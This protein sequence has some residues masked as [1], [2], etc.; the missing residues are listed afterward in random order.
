MSMTTQPSEKDDWMNAEW[1]H[2]VAEAKAELLGL[3]DDRDLMAKMDNVIG[4]PDFRYKLA[5]LARVLGLL[6]G[7]LEKWEPKKYSKQA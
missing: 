2:C 3:I 4:D 1:D 5:T 7:E 6:H